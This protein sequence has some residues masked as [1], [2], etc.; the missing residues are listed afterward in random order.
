[1]KR[2]II[3]TLIIVLALALAGIAIYR[4]VNPA[5]APVQPEPETVFC[6]ADAMMCPDGSYVGRVA[7]S[8]AFAACPTIATS[9]SEASNE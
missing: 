5:P 1:M 6:T 2:F 4:Q 7:P 3:P 8:C 9:T